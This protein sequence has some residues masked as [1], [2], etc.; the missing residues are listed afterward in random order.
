MTLQPVAQKDFVKPRVNL[1]PPRV[2]SS[3]QEAV[4][5]AAS[6]GLFLDPW[7]QYV[8]DAALGERSNGTWSAFE[9]GLVV[10]RQQGKGSILEA[11]ELAG[12]FLF[13]EQMILHTS[14]EYKTS[15]EAFLRIRS[16]VER[17]PEIRQLVKTIRTANGEESIEAKNG[18]RLR[19]LSRSAGS[20]RG[21]S[22]DCVILDE[23]YRLGGD[24][25]SALLPTLSSRPN[26]QLWY[27]SMAGMESSEQLSLVRDRALANGKRL[28]YLEWG[29][30]E[31]ADLDDRSAWRGANPAFDIR[32]PEE[33]IEREREALS[34][35]DF[36]RERLNIWGAS[37][38]RSVINLKHWE[39]LKDSKSEQKIP[40]LLLSI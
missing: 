38:P 22:G 36:A 7:Q 16:L 11:R 23:A 31:D 13:Q 19:F 14:H 18:S 1:V 6:A 5:L 24:A 35:E 15:R 4:E 37:K 33:F 21:F 26:P 34:D 20:G 17:S 40:S 39:V 32:I 3:G 9:V 8:L 28:C 27:T 25:M 2:S 30:H 12:L 10:P 29:A